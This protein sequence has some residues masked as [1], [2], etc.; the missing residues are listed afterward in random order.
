M[1]CAAPKH[2]SIYTTLIAE[3]RNALFQKSNL[4]IVKK[5]KTLMKFVITDVV[6]FDHETV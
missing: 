6:Y 3:S 1:E 2:W 4:M 5:T